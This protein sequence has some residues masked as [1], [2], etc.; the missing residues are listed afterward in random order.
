[1]ER[2]L[3]MTGIGGQGIQL[4]S[5]VLA[6]AALAEGLDVQLFGSYG[7]MMRGGATEATVVVGDAPV[8]APPTLSSAWSAIVMHQEH[9]EHARSCVRP[10]SVVLVNA[11]LDLE[12]DRHGVQVVEVPATDIATG[13]GHAMAASMVMMGAYTAVTGIVSL[14]VLARVA[15]GALPSYRTQHIE[16][17]ERAIAA[18]AA[19]VVPLSAPAWV[20][21]GGA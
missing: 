4:A 6:S 18:G 19:A 3:V 1:V 2:E 12:I 14:E 15:R 9:S 20:A 21:S 8:E 17:N 13:I 7:G 5:S 16:L 11:S 10:G